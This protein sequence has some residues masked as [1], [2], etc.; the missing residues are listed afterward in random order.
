M[1]KSEERIQI[2]EKGYTI[3]QIRGAFSE[4]RV[5]RAKVKILEKKVKSYEIM[6]SRF[7]GLEKSRMRKV[8]SSNFFYSCYSS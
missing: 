3:A 8:L 1:R 6:E 5:L 4:N 2:G 7:K